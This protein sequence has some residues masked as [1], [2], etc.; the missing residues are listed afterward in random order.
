[1]AERHVRSNPADSV[2][3][4]VATLQDYLTLLAIPGPYC[5]VGLNALLSSTVLTANDLVCF[6]PFVYS[7]ALQVWTPHMYYT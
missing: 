3:V 5:S 7:S 4:V 6:T 2:A 1:M